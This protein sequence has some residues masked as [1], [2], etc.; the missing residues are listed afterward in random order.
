RWPVRSVL[1]GRRA[2]PAARDR[3][4][5]RTSG[6]SR[7]APLQVPSL[8]SIALER[9]EEML[10]RPKQ[11]RPDGADRA[12]EHRGRFLV[13]QLLEVDQQ[14]GGEKRLRQLAQRRVDLCARS[15]GAAVEAVERV[16]LAVHADRLFEA[17]LQLLVGERLRLAPGQAGGGAE[18]RKREV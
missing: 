1:P 14:D 6:C 11:P 12:L 18:N 16:G 17:T 10:P 5:R 7:R 2:G 3:D 15:P 9:R 4:A 13:R 8:P